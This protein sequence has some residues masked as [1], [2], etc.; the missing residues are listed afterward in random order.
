M[1]P[2]S[3]SLG[4]SLRTAFGLSVCASGLFSAAEG[5]FS[6]EAASAAIGTV[7]VRNLNDVDDDSGQVCIFFY[8]G[9]YGML[10]SQLLKNWHVVGMVRGV[11][12]ITQTSFLASVL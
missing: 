7:V 10:L 11:V 3:K 6:S 4:L 2:N 1:P 9:P 5:S 12:S 8:C